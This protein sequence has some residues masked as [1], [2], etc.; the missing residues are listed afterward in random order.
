M[1]RSTRLPVPPACSPAMPFSPSGA[2]C[3]AGVGPG[4]RGCAVVLSWAHHA[5]P[6]ACSALRPTPTPAGRL[7]RGSLRIR[8]QPLHLCLCACAST[9]HMCVC[10]SCVLAQAPAHILSGLTLC[11]VHKPRRCTAQHLA[12]ARASLPALQVVRMYISRPMR[13]PLGVVRQARRG[14]TGRPAAVVS[15]SLRG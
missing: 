6:R 1:C 9:R 13:V 10:A 7:P 11:V 14:F 5:I 15:S 3:R 8:I 12:P 2:R 4:C